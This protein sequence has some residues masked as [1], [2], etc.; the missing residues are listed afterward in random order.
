M[1]CIVKKTFEAVH[2]AKGE[3]VVQL[4][5]N[6]EFLTHK[7]EQIIRR[8]SEVDYF[9]ETEKTVIELRREQLKYSS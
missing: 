5:A 7:I 4:K 2:E 1:L 9:I 8:N 6:Q 3:L